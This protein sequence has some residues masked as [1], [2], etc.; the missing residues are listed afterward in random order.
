MMTPHEVLPDLSGDVRQV[1]EE[2]DAFYEVSPRNVVLEERTA[3]ATVTTRKVLAGFDIAVYGT[4]TSLEVRSSSTYQLAFGVL[5]K[6]A[7]TIM[8]DAGDS[9]LIDVARFYST[10]VIDTKM[11]FQPMAMLEVTITHNRGLDQPIGAAELYALKQI[12]QQLNSL[13]LNCRS[14]HFT[15]KE[16]QAVYGDCPR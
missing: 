2:H 3:R 12:K 4:K 15:F 1:I 9:C 14:E 6:V 7:G 16:W 13:G 8:T 5:T 11:H 10:T